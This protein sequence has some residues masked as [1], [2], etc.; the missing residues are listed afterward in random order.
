MIPD[1]DPKTGQLPIGIHE[2]TW[3]E[4]VTR[5][6]TNVRRRKLIDGL[7]LALDSLKQAG[8]KTAYIDGS[9]VTSK[10][11]P[12]DFDG[13]WDGIGVDSDLL[14]PE[15]LVLN[16]GRIVQKEKYGGEL[17]PLQLTAD[18]N[19]HNYLEFFQ[20]TR[21]GKPKGIVALNLEELL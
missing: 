3:D 6:A 10:N 9:F 12:R 19:G 11:Y 14:D 2:A 21:T 1:F 20:F 7:K 16:R 15:L 18:E 5:F 4:F 17:F 8:C 13:C